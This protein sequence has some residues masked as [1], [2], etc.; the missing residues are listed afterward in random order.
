MQLYDIGT[1]WMIDSGYALTM[2]DLIDQTGS[3][4]SALEP[5]IL[6][7]YSIDGKL[8]SMPFNSSTPI[9]YYNKD[10]FAAAGLDPEKPPT[11]FDELV[12]YSEALTIKD[13]NT[14]TQYG[15]ALRIYGWFFEQFLV[16][17]NQEF[18]N[19][20]NGRDGD[21][22]T[23]VAFDTNGEIGRAHV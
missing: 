4:I 10:A 19:N 21:G 7:Y 5:N 17:Q 18:A 8:Y 23:A 3:D 16:K 6:D 20:G 2:Q 15:S 1:R 22:A 9:L 11:T 14:I 13:G 12:Q